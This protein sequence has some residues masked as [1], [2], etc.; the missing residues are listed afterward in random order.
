MI[1]L[2]CEQSLFSS[3][4]HGKEC[5]TSK[6]ASSRDCEHDMGAA[7]LLAASRVGIGRLAKRETALVSCNNLKAQHSGDGVIL[8]VGL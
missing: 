3:K 1:T 2:G 8:L 5:E 6:H 4:I 7:M